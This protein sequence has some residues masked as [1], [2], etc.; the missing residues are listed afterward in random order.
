MQETWVGKIPWR[1]ERLPT[2]VF[3]PRKL[4]RLYSPWGHKE[5]DTTERLSL[6]LSLFSTPDSSTVSNK[7]QRGCLQLNKQHP[8]KRQ[9]TSQQCWIIFTSSSVQFNHS[10][11][12]ES[13]QPH[14]L[15]H[16]R[17]PCPSPTRG[18][19]SNSHPLSRWCHPTISPSAVPFFSHLQSFP[20]SGSF[21]VN[22]LFTSGGPSIGVSASASVLP[23]N[24]QDWFPLG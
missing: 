24:T 9:S 6:W 5:L 23:M 10:V 21:S 14:G 12:P 8:Y 16:S 7:G 11:V 20:A 18:V 13:L 22:R 2:P 17:L 1:R 4:H 15:Q 3:W 19:Y